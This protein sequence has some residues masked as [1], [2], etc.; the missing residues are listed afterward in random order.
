MT[1]NKIIKHIK[2]TMMIIL[3]FQVNSLASNEIKWGLTIGHQPHAHKKIK[4]QNIE[5]LNMIEKSKT[6]NNLYYFVTNETVKEFGIERAIGKNKLNNYFMSNWQKYIDLIPIEQIVYYNLYRAKQSSK[7]K[8]IKASKEPMKI[9]DEANTIATIKAFYNL[10]NESY[11]KIFLSF[12]ILSILTIIIFLIVFTILTYI[13]RLLKTQYKLKKIDLNTIKENEEKSLQIIQQEHDKLDQRRLQTNQWIEKQNTLKEDQTKIINDI[14]SLNEQKTILEINIDKLQQETNDIK[15]YKDKI[16]K[17]IKNEVYQSLDKERKELEDII[18][19]KK[20]QRKMIEN[21]NKKYKEQKK[22]L[23]I[24]LNN[25][26][27]RIFKKLM[28]LYKQI[29][30]MNQDKIKKQA[31]II[32]Q[33]PDFNFLQE[34]KSWEKYLELLDNNESVLYNRINA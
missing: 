24:K 6:K 12:N 26:S 23:A 15:I 3:I 10:D 34:E 8:L 1:I 33:S 29:K 21:E 5:L 18:K 22:E 9:I 16:Y 17:E 27:K 13:L 4:K 25:L 32:L 19:E 30:N 14:Q 7:D 28:I 2:I 20:N 11:K 31:E